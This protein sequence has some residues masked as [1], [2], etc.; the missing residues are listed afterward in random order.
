MFAIKRGW[1]P[2]QFVNNTQ[3]PVFKNNLAAIQRVFDWA[4]PVYVLW[5]SMNGTNE[6]LRKR[7]DGFHDWDVNIDGVAHYGMLPDML[8]DMKNVGVTPV[9]LAPLFSS[10]EDYI[11][12]WERANKAS[13]SARAVLP[14]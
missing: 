2:A 14:K 6:P 8:Q 11:L 7:V 9:Q 13:A 12:M 4:R 1:T 5:N 3:R 10:A